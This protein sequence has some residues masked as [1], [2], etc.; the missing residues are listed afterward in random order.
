MGAVVENKELF[1]SEGIKSFH[2]VVIDGF[3]THISISSGNAFLNLHY[4]KHK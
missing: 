2:L 4:N 3:H 1:I